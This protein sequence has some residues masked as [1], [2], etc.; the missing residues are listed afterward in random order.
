MFQGFNAVFVCQNHKIIKAEKKGK[1][2]TI[3]SLKYNVK[4][5]TQ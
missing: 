2:K 3:F 5:I 1:N 4:T